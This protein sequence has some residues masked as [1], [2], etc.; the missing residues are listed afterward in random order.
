MRAKIKV[1]ASVNCFAT[2]RHAR[3]RQSFTHTPPIGYYRAYQDAVPKLS[4]TRALIHALAVLYALSNSAIF[5][6]LAPAPSL[7]RST[8]APFLSIKNL[9]AKFHRTFDDDGST[10]TEPLGIG[11]VK[12]NWY[13]MGL[14]KAF[15]NS[16]SSRCEQNPTCARSNL[17]HT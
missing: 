7:F 16:F 6:S 17:S 3:A 5:P 12:A 15:C 8:T 10:F 11:I 9:Q 4:M 1:I 13:D 2:T 14:W